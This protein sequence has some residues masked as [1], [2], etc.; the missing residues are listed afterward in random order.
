MVS[1]STGIV[2][3]GN[4]P[5][6]KSLYDSDPWTITNFIRLDNQGFMRMEVNILTLERNIKT[7]NC[8]CHNWT[9]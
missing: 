9:Q 2:H 8:T 6:K 1:E 5:A 4:Y 7:V 3:I